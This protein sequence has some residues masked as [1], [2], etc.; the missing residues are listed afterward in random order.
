MRYVHTGLV[1]SSEEKAD[2]FYHDLLGLKKLNVKT[3]PALLSK[4]LFNQD[5]DLQV[6]NYTNDHLHFEIFILAGH[7]TVDNP[8]SHTCIAVADRDGLIQNCKTERVNVIEVPK[9][10]SMLVF[11]SDFDGNFFEV[12]AE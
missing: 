3:L 2:R 12:K 4:S 10:D 11:I 5:T 7:E 1:C 8:I 6:I 9:D